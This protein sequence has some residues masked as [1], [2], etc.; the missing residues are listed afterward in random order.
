[1]QAVCMELKG[2]D[3]ELDSAKFDVVVVSAIQYLSTQTK[4]LINVWVS[5]RQRTITLNPLNPSPKP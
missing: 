5:V 1:M 3:D 2:T 4:K